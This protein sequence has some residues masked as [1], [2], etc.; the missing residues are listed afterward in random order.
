MRPDDLVF[1]YVVNNYLMGRTPPAFDILAWNADGTNLPGA[2]HAQFL[3]FFRGN[4]LTKPGAATVLDT[5]VDLSTV[6]LPTFVSGAID[7][8]LTAWKN[9]YRTT[10]LLGG[11]DTTFVLSFSG[12]I[13]SLVNPPG[14]PKSHYWTGGKPGA[15]PQQ[16]LDQ[17]D[18]VSGTWWEAWADWVGSRSG[19]RVS[20]PELDNID[21][22]LGPAPGRY[23]R[24]LPA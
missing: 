14:N 4:H 12:H 17:A 7:D 23:V 20:S 15:D 3:D 18:R 5:P 8:H 11:D 6:T 24:D 2:L 13:A 19:E 21:R 22:P 1:N 9:C 10:Q 16:W